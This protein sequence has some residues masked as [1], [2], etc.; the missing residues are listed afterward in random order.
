MTSRNTI[1]L[2]VLFTLL[3]GCGALRPGFETPTVNVSSFKTVPS[4]GV[5]PAFEIGLRVINP[6]REA[7]ELAGVAYT[8]SL[9]GNDLIKGV[10]SDLPVIPGYGEGDFKLTASA[11][12][13]AGARLF[14]ELMRSGKSSVS[15]SFEARLDL[16]GLQPTI[17]VRDKGEIS[18]QPQR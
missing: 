13:L 4:D 5:F 11:N 7:L 10:A 8:I 6:N 14:T 12:L 15:Y 3:A 17:R 1:L 9:E 16:T 18:L 2:L